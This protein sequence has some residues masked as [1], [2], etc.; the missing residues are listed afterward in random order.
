[1]YMT[2]LKMT[3]S[4]ILNATNLLDVNNANAIH[5]WLCSQQDSSR[6]EAG[7]L[8]RV[9]NKND[10]VFMYIQ[11]KAPFNV[12]NVADFGFEFL[13]SFD[14]SSIDLNKITT[15]DIQCFPCKQKDRKSFFIKN[16]ADRYEWLKQQ[17]EKHGIQ[18]ISC[19]EYKLSNIVMIKNKSTRFETASY[20]G[21][22]KVADEILALDLLI[23]GLGRL[24]NYGCGLVL[25]R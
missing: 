21:T 24:K 23:S 19:M 15:F 18:L 7:L 11:S 25:V 3:R 22:I 12:D 9:I 6:S 2:V 8:Y 13:K 16:T 1:M 14:L 4:S 10:D 17:F 20:R 5:Q